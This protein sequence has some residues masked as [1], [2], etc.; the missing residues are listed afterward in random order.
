MSVKALTKEAHGTERAAG[1]L[2][3]ALVTGLERRT[4]AS[5]C[6]PRR[7]AASDNYSRQLSTRPTERVGRVGDVLP[8]ERAGG[9]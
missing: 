8:R 2:L 9:A 7:L 1:I 4:V 6:Q 5:G 3:R